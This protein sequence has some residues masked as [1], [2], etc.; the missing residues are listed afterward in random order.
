VL[1]A[2][3]VIKILG[4]HF[5][6]ALVNAFSLNMVAGTAML[7]VRDVPAEQVPPDATSA[8]GHKETAE[9]VSELLG[10]SVQVNRVAI[11]L[12]PGDTAY[13]ATLFTAEGKPFRPPEG[14]ILS[15]DEL[16]KLK[17]AIRAVTVVP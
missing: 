5:M 9:V 13:V 11:S 1:P 12:K 15:A 17:I 7:Q 3:V 6:N 16:R 4:F 2:L 14:V 8:I 10:R